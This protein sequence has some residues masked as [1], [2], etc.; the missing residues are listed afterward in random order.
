MKQDKGELAALEHA[1]AASAAS[2]MELS[3]TAPVVVM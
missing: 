3:R 1:M 2:A